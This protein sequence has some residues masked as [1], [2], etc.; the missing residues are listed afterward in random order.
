MGGWQEWG[1]GYPVPFPITQLSWFLII[2]LFIHSFIQI[3][4]TEHLLSVRP[5]GSEISKSQA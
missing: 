1:V 5:Q 2:H 3:I 4:F